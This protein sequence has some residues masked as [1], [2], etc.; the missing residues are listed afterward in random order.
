MDILFMK[1]FLY[2]QHY[3]ISLKPHF[4]NREFTSF[5]FFILNIKCA[6]VCEIRFGID[7]I[8]SVICN[9]APFIYLHLSKMVF[10]FC[11]F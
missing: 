2:N 3:T 6:H 8:K 11:M 9:T 1:I 10:G 4:K 5:L 7:R